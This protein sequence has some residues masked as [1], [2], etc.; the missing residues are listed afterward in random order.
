MESMGTSSHSRI[1]KILSLQ[2][3]LVRVGMDNQ[4]SLRTCTVLYTTRGSMTVS[5]PTQTPHEYV[6]VIYKGMNR[7]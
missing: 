5:N 4:I 7:E 1:Y 2:F 3:A 6:H